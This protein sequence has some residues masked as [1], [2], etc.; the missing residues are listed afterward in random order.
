MGS[1]RKIALMAWLSW[2]AASG[3][4]C[5][6]GVERGAKK[7]PVAVEV[8]PIATQAITLRRSFSGSLEAAAA[9]VVSPKIAGRVKRMHVDLG[10]RVT[11]GQV[12]VELD[13]DE[14]R[15]QV[16]QAKAELAVATATAAE[17]QSALEIAH[18][19]LVRVESLRKKGIASDTRLDATRASHQAAEA[20]RQ[21]AEAQVVRARAALQGAQIRLGYTRITADWT[22]GDDRRV[23]AERHVDEGETVAANA[24]LLSIVEMDPILG[25]IFVPERDYTRLRTGAAVTLSTDAYPG[26][27]FESRIQRIAPVFRPGSRQARVELVF[28]NPDGR[29]KPG[30][31]IRASVALEH[32]EKAT[33]VP[34]AALAIRGEQTGVF[35]VDDGGERVRWR[36]V[37][38]GIREGERVQVTGEGL[39]GRVVTLGQ[40]LLD[41]GSAIS[42]SRMPAAPEAEAPR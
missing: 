24:P 23:V 11:R 1:L 6:S 3:S 29:L 18:R 34:E 5:D 4:G 36:P 31:F 8:A 13:D 35:V 33:V 9:F 10:D 22:E 30:L 17:A 16:V 20:R 41:D 21:V 40:Q 12:V 19:E 38:V 32:A 39:R 2:L 7:R 26:E 15:Q 14:A 25:V 42:L 37:Q 27:S 28:E